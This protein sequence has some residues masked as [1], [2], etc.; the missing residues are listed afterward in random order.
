VLLLR[1]LKNIESAVGRVTS[2]RNGPRAIDLDIV[3]Y[4]DAS[5][6]TRPLS[7]RNDLDNLTGELVV[8]HPRMTEREFVLRPMNECVFLAQLMCGG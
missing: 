6:D 3:L 7:Q 1:F 5:I 8:P 4:G 2:I